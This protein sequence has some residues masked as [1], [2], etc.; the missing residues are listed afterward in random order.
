M[1]RRIGVRLVLVLT[2]AT[3]RAT[4]DL[5]RRFQ[6]HIDY[7]A[8]VGL[9]RAFRKT[10]AASLPTNCINRGVSQARPPVPA[11]RLNLAQRFIAGVAVAI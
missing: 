8:G 5:Q 1:Q 11:G 3:S 2:A 9:E 6:Q 4:S 10:P 7:L